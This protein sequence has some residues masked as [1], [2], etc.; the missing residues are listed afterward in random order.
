M[1]KHI[2]TIKE[3]LQN[4]LGVNWVEENETVSISPLEADEINRSPINYGI[5]D[6]DLNRLWGFE[7][8]KVQDLLPIIEKNSNKIKK[9]AL[10]VILDTGI[11]AAHEDI[12]ENYK[13]IKEK[14]DTDGNMH[15]THCA[16][17][18][19]SVN[20]NGKG[21]A[22]FNA[23]SNLYNVS[24]IKVL[25]GMGTG[26]Q[27]VIISGMIEAADNGAD[28]IS[29]SLGGRSSHTKQRAY[30]KAVEY[31]NKKGAIVVVAAGNSNVDAI[32]ATPANAE[33]VITVSA[34]ND[35]MTKAA[36]S[37]TV[38]SLKMGIA[39]PGKNIYSTIPKN[40]Y[41]SLNGTSMATPYVAAALAMLKSFDP[42]LTTKEA[43]SIL[44]ETGIKTS[45]TEQT[46]KF[47]QPAAALNRL[48]K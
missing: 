20:N 29:M 4:T 22:S 34:T 47:I 23:N 2:T 32:H 10:L 17:I 12:K 42:E 46:G 6:P 11:D 24:S 48:L 44:N 39:A 7:K 16:G 3:K 13:S 19:A 18:A 14:H 37:N 31:A 27:N 1:K 38:Q 43:F 28:V 25:S 33:G 30:N 26:T 9:K 8:M 15:G 35:Q 40:Q 21:I 45:Q 36:F 41:K 5:D